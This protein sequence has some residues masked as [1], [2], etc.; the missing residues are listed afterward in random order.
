MWKLLRTDKRFRRLFI[1]ESFSSFG[2]SAVYLSL[3]IWIKDL[4]GS[5]A[6]AGVVFLIITA[7]GLAAPLLGHWVDRVRRRP[8]LL[9]MYAVMAVLVLSLLFVDGSGDVWIIYLVTLAYGVLF[10][11]PARPALLKDLL[12]S[13][14]AAEA[15]SLLITVREGVRIVSPVAGAG[16]Y[17]AFGGGALAV[18]GSAT[19]VVAALVLWSIQVVE[20]EPEPA[21][22]PFARSVTA[23]FRFVRTVPF[24]LRLTLAMVGFLAVVGLLETAVFAAVDQGLGQ[25]A[26]FVGVIASLQGAGSV[27]GGIL[28][29]LLV[30]RVGEFR[31][32]AA[33]Y[34][35]IA[36]GLV[37][38]VWR[39]LPLFVL[40]SMLVGVGLPFLMVALS[41]ALHLYAPA[42]MQGR[43][44]AAV[45]SVCDL[46]QT[47]SIAA[48]AALIGLID[49]RIMYALM[50]VAALMCA[51]SL[52][53][54]RIA[55]PQVS[56]SVADA[57]DAPDAPEAPAGGA[58]APP[59]PSDPA[60]EEL[61]PAR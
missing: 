56:H 29:G 31:G 46:F 13:E 30:K 16:V 11:T 2:D 41:T 10:A 44:N 38:C 5:D 32:S 14:N 60:D 40:G 43:V 61:R 35:L 33:G 7:P 27:L 19:F 50:G 54:R 6:A 28:A 20:S 49:Y 59:D 36:V 51:M 23:G 8:L 17:T 48:G 12:A 34:G 58:G 53:M 37:L 21:G 18:L 55:A 25:G 39:E 22:E 42:R 52:L 26:A 24:L 47:L 1:G 45:S 15:R 57:P 9:R 3:A 4:T